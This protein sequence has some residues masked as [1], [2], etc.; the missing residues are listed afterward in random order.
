MH[1]AVRP[2]RTIHIPVHGNGLSMMRVFAGLGAALITLLGASW[3]S[4]HEGHDHDA[5]PL[6]ASVSIAPRAEATSDAFELI[7]IAEGSEL[8]I[9]LDRFATNESVEGAAIEVETPNGPITA[10]THGDAYRVPATWL[11]NPGRYDLIFTVTA[12]EGADVLP[13][14]LEIPEARSEST[15]TGDPSARGERWSG[16]ALLILGAAAG[17][18]IGMTAMAFF[19][20]GR[21]TAISVL[22]LAAATIFGANAIAHEGEDHGPSSEAQRFAS[23][24][25]AQLLSDGSVFVPKATQRI[26]AIRTALTEQGRF[27][28]AIELPGRIIPDPNASGYVQASVGGRLSPPPGGFPKLGTRVSQ[29]D[30]LAFVTPPIQAIDVSDMRQRQGELD[31]QIS[32]VERRVARYEPLVQSGSITRVQLDEARLELQGLKD[33]RAALDKARREPEA[34]IAPVSGIVAEG[35]VAAGQIAQPNTV[36]FQIVDPERLWIEALSFNALTGTQTA[37]ARSPSGRSLPLKYQ[38]SGFTDR[39]QSIPIH[40]SIEGDV[41]GLRVG[42]FVTVLANTDEERNGLAVPRGSV[43]RSA[44]GQDVVYEHV[45]AERFQ[46]RLVRIEPLD[47]ERV[48]IATGIGPGR[49]VVTQGAE[50]LDQVR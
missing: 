26:L 31:Q 21:T 7:A 30:V 47:G 11:S 3:L 4:A 8:A 42:Q 22:L 29:G 9:Y 15:P 36:V 46:A 27:R 12:K 40:F 19:R 20:G 6:P 35:V 28:R 16:Q 45:T 17:F 32:I 34:L 43:V 48:L 39:N 14:T 24:D 1:C 38:G 44:N 37:T 13:L 2:T 50:L 5:A 18:V 10:R 23:R 49:R 41:T 33:R 25:L